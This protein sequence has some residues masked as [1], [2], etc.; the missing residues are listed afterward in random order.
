MYEHSDMHTNMPTHTHSHTLTN[1][2]AHTHARARAACTLMQPGSVAHT[3]YAPLLR[4][5]LV[6]LVALAVELVRRALYLKTKQHDEA[7]AVAARS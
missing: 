2:R 7:E 3:A 5:L 6:E 4:Q 1:A